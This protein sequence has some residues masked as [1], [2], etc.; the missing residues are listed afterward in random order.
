M[1]TTKIYKNTTKKTVSV[2]GL[3][4]IKAGEQISVVSEYHQPIVLSNYPGV[5]ELVEEEQKALDAEKESK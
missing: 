5:V 4:E 2:F 1:V 3:G